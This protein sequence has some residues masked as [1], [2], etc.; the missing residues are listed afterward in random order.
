MNA[1]ADQINV[2]IVIPAYNAESTIGETLRSVLRQTHPHWEAI[3][4]DDGSTDETSN[5]ARR[6]AEHDPRVH[7]ISQANGGESA[8]R[9]AGIG[10]SRCDWLL[11]LDA[12][13]WIAPL[14]LEKMTAALADDRTL[15]AVL[16]SYARVA[17]DGTEIEDPYR[18]PVGDLFSTLARR[19]AFPVHACVVRKAIVDE[20]GPFDTSLRT[21]ADWDLWQRVA[22]TGACFGAIRDVL[23]FYRMSPR[24]ASLDADRLFRDGLR[25][26]QQGAAPDPRV[27]RPHPDHAQGSNEPILTQQ[28]YLLAWCA[29]L[30]IGTGRD[31]RPLLR[32][33]H[34][35]RFP[36][37]YPD[38]VAECLFAAAPLPACQAPTAW[39]HLWRE[40]RPR[41]QEFLVGLE[42]QSGAPALARGAVGG[43]RRRILGVSPMWSLMQD[44]LRELKALADEERDAWQ[45]LAEDRERHLQE[46]RRSQTLL[47]TEKENWQRIAG[48][49]RQQFDDLEGQR[50]NWQRV[51]EVRTQERDQFQRQSKDASAKVDELRMSDERKLGD[52]LLNRLRLRAPARGATAALKAI[53]QRLSVARLAAERRLSPR[54][55]RHRVVA[56]ACDVFPIYSQTFVYQ[57]LTQL[58][59]QEF[60]IRFVYSKLDDRDFL[61]SQFAWLWPSKRRLF[62]SSSV[63]DSDFAYYTRRLPQRVEELITRLSDAAGMTR[64]ALTTHGNFLQAFSFTRMVEAYRPEYLHSYFF[65]DRSLMTLI[66]GYLLDIPRGISCYADHALQDYE[67]KVVPLHLQLCDI[68]IATSERIKDELMRIA[69]GCDPNRILVKPNGIDTN[70]FPAI[71]RADP[72]DGEPFRLIALCRIEPKKGLLDLV[73]AVH[74]LRQRGLMVEAHIVG[75]VDE[76]S[77]ASRDYKAQLDQ[78]ISDLDMWGRVHL[79]G[80]HNLSGIQRFLQMGHIFVA[81]FVE[82]ASGD[83]D[84]IP[85]A[86]LEGMATGLPAVA[87][88]AGSIAEVIIDE[89]NGVLVPQHDPTALASAIEALLTNPERREALGRRA[90]DSI[91]RRFDVESCERIFHD[92][93]RDVLAARAG[94]RSR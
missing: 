78:R 28:Y 9:N 69:P 33:V 51:A 34:G 52:L 67:L 12:D 4:V 75:T 88:T 17:A 64:E 81:P 87:T 53:G 8:A 35:D 91:R 71:E 39:N 32:I 80:R 85:T 41:I 61:Q 76:W 18:P 84:G 89:E 66:A 24:G 62:L 47:E 94:G 77:Q 44:E 23:A 70:R 72:N 19:A 57:E 65:Y 90:A 37:L 6:L 26:L 54:S 14:H 48:E 11:F 21:S 60:E 38:A 43:L 92:R 59:R 86:L 50:A 1:R 3:V 46:I 83:K 45:R 29:G 22:R 13:D 10:R 40:L 74:Q 55:Q 25:V 63:H 7:V 2:S 79:E 82:T 20:V 68:V 31:A 73:D 56:T 42:E 15:D 49:R 93:L 58:A 27:P 16:C 30:L 36:E 5:R